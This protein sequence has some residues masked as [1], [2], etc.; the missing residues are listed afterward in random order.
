MKA[1][2]CLYFAEIYFLHMNAFFLS[3]SKK[4]GC[5]LLLRGRSDALLFLFLFAWCME[6]RVFVGAHVCGAAVSSICG[7]MTQLSLTMLW[8]VSPNA[9]KENFTFYSLARTGSEFAAV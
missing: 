1:P 4:R 9:R 6:L 5:T 8:E 7:D 2:T 3:D